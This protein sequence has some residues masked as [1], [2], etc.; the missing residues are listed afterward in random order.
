MNKMNKIFTVIERHV[1]YLLSYIN[2]RKYMFF[3]TKWL[4]KRGV[5]IPDYKNKGFIHKTANIDG[6]DYSLI[7]V[8]ENVV[9]SRDVTILVHDFSI[10][11]ALDSIGE[12]KE[13]HS[14]CFMKSV[15]IGENSFIGAGAII[16][17]GSHI[18]KNV[19]IGAGSVIKGKIPDNTIWIGNPAR[20]CTTIEEF[21]NR[22]IKIKD[23]YD[24]S[25]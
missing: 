2:V 18:G 1:I 19:I 17:P 12:N 10:R 16:L 25:L 6:S 21:A 23:Y 15:S 7:T 3:Y 8:G 13:N 20:Q 24:L 11:N 14:L 4:Q 9:I 22:H 5:H